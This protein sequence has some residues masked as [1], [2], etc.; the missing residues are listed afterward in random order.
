MK[1]ILQMGVIFAVCLASEAISAA[2]PFAFPASVIGMVLLLV[3]LAAKVVRPG[4]LAQLSSFLLDNMPLFF[5]PACVGILRYLD[6]LLANLFPIL[7][8]CIGTVPLVFFV[9]GHTVQLAIRW[10]DRKEKREGGA[11]DA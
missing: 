11:K 4:Q 3:L 1:L 7:L 8:I 5:I 9:T 10:M 6:A 2:L